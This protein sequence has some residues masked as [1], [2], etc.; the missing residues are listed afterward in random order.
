MRRGLILLAALG[1]ACDF[2]TRGS[3]LLR[4][5]PSVEVPDRGAV[6]D[7]PRADGPR[8]DR[9]Q[10]PLPVD[11]GPPPV[12][13]LPPS[14]KDIPPSMCQPPMTWCQSQAIC[15]DLETDDLN[16]GACGSQCTA[17][18]RCVSKVCCPVWKMFCAGGCVD[19]ES[20]TDHCGGCGNKCAAGEQCLT[21]VCCAPGKAVCGGACVDLASDRDNCGSCGKVCNPGAPCTNGACAGTPPAIACKSGV[22]DQVFAAG[23]RGCKGHVYFKDRATLC[24][25]PKFRVCTAKEWVAKHAGQ[26]PTHIYWTNDVL[27][28]EG[29]SKD[30]YVS[31]QKLTWCGPSSPMRVCS[32]KQDTE[33]NSCNWTDCGLDTKTPNVFFGGCQGNWTAG[34]L[35]CE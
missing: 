35:C 32:G 34:A 8:L 13:D 17:G 20:S 21:G 31:T 25:A 15:T 14:T 16:C 28:A 9:P 27:Y 4:D 24:N 19:V 33:Y 23:M 26:A 3:A 2:D 29:K 5:A 12:Q 18:N 7:G 30:C 6:G 1:V 10:K 22:E 11:L